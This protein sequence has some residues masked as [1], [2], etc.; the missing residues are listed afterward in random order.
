MPESLQQPVAPQTSFLEEAKA[1]IESRLPLLK[2]LLLSN[3]ADVA[4]V[5][6]PAITGLVAAILDSTDRPCC[7]VLPDH[8]GMALAVSTLVSVSR[9]A[10]DVPDILRVHANTSFEASPGK[11]PV[12]V[13][14]HPSGLVYEYGGFFDPEFFRLKVL[15]RNEARSLP[16]KEVARLERTLKKRPKGYGNSDLGRPQPTVLG[17]LV[18]IPGT[19]NRNF[20]RNYV[21][22]LSTKKHLKDC[23]QAW[24]IAVEGHALDGTLGEEIPCGELD[25]DGGLSFLD[26]YIASGEP[27]VAVA[28]S[29]DDL[30]AFCAARDPHSV[31]VIVDDVERLARNLQAY[32]TIAD[33]QRVVILADDSQHEAVGVLR[34]RGCTVWHL[35]PE[36]VLMGSGPGAAAGPLNVLL[37]KASNMRDLVVAPSACACNVLDEAAADLASAA[38]AIPADN[39]N[40]TVRD[41]FLTL[42]GTLMLCAEHLG[43]EEDSFLGEIG[44][45]LI[46]AKSLLERA[47][48]WIA[49]EIL[50]EIDTVITRLGCAAEELSVNPITPKG[51]ALLDCLGP[52]ETSPLPAAVVTRSEARR[53]AVQKWLAGQGRRIPVYRVS[54]VPG[55]SQF[56]QL[57]VVSWPSARRFDRL[58]RLYTTQRLLVL[59]Y[60]FERMWLREY[61]K[62]YDQA[63]PAYLSTRKKSI[64]LGLHQE[65]DGADEPLPPPPP[66]TG[67][68]DL[69]EER[70][71][72]RRKTVAAG[73]AAAGNGLD[74]PIEAHYVDFVGPTF[75]YLTEGHELPVVNDYVTGEHG[76][77]GKV[78]FR[79]I[80]ELKVGDFVMFRG[81]GDSDI[82]R[83]MVEDEIGKDTYQKL[84][85]TATRWKSALQRIGSDPQEVWEKLRQ[86]GFS[87]HIQTVRAWLCNPHMIAPKNPEDI[88]I[89]ARASGDQELLDVLPGIEQ[90]IS[91][92]NGHHIKAGKRLTS[93]LLRELP[94]RLEVIASGETEVDLGFGKVWIVRIEEIDGGLTPVNYTIVNRLL[95]DAEYVR[96]GG[97]G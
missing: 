6:L 27:L 58:L 73:V 22:V 76:A 21:A 62:R 57:V 86:F 35:S 29:P 18:G 28:S 47:E 8:Q 71:L 93:E 54:E 19:V 14:V 82:I 26:K 69:P 60:R 25:E 84:R 42:F 56:E 83:F 20:L 48:I 87:R 49:P 16:V 92:I 77:A 66:P 50:S 61:K 30:A 74:E 38:R 15:D 43:S 89:I 17:T 88:R 53:D 32:D 81:T 78:P 55:N 72:I 94:R 90:A 13:L 85:A 65:V 97:A 2:R 24:K 44:K 63:A 91:E 11:E 40:A 4:P 1:A 34:E 45:R 12:R 79:P 37:T 9:L 80:G 23:L 95:W 51:Q 41:L 96:Q 64:L 70:F 31:A 7:L 10:R 3:Q 68:F 39:D 59:A 36:E 5:R 75:A 46:D 52:P 33:R 67:P